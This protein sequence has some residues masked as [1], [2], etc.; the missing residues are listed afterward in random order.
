MPEWGKP[1]GVEMQ[2]EAWARSANLPPH[3][4][5]TPQT[6]ISHKLDLVVKNP[7]RDQTVI[8]VSH[9]T[10]GQLKTWLIEQFTYGLDCT[11]AW[12]AWELTREDRRGAASWP[13]AGTLMNVMLKSTP[14]KTGKLHIRNQRVYRFWIPAPPQWM[15][16]A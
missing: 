10:A 8:H 16:S 14:T 3:M 7:K 13:M 5:Q 2:M 12:A 11:Q 9:K 15:R 1:I 4:S 6:P